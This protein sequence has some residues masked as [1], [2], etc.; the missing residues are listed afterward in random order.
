MSSISALARELFEASCGIVKAQK[1]EDPHEDV[2]LTVMYVPAAS[3]TRPNLIVPISNGSVEPPQML[4]GALIAAYKAWGPP[5]I[6]VH[7]ADT[8][9]KEYPPGT[10]LEDV[11]YQRGDYAND[12][13]SKELLLI[14][15]HYKDEDGIGTLT[16]YLPY[17]YD[18]DGSIRFDEVIDDITSLGG[19]FDEIIRKTFRKEAS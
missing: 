4:A 16:R 18:D 19:A 2:G 6:I 10:K 12:P 3:P 8:H 7:S 11:E 17:G 5:S 15:A 9:M 1:L 14:S 13:T